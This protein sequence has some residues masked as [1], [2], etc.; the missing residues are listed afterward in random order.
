[1]EGGTSKRFPILITGA[2]WLLLII[3]PFIWGMAPVAFQKL[4]STDDY[5]RMVQVA[6]FMA[7][8]SDSSFHQERLGPAWAPSEMHWT[9]LVDLP[10]A[11]SVSFFQLFMNHEQA[12]YWTATFI[13][14]TLLLVLLLTVRWTAKPL[15][16]QKT[17]LVAIVVTALS[18][19]MLRQF[20]LGGVD[21]HAWQILLV[22][23]GYGC[24]FR[25]IIKPEL[26]KLAVLAGALFAFGLAIGAEILPWVAMAALLQAW[27][28]LFQGERHLRNGLSLG[29]SLCATT[30]LLF[31]VVRFPWE[32]LTHA[33]DTISPAFIFFTASIPLFWLCVALLRGRLPEFKSRLIAASIIGLGVIAALILFI[34]EC[35]RGIYA[36]V[37]PFVKDIWLSHVTEA[38]PWHLYVQ[39]ETAFGFFSLIPLAG[40]LAGCVWACFKDPQKRILWS[41][42]GLVIFCSLCLLMIQVRF[43]DFAGA[44]AII[45]FSWFIVQ[46]A[47]TLKSAYISRLG[48]PGRLARVGMAL[49]FFLLSLVFFLS[50]MDEAVLSR[51]SGQRAS[52]PTCDM[53]DLAEVLNTL[54]PGAIAADIDYGPELLFRTR[55]RVLAA[56]YHRNSAGIKGAFKI[57]SAPSNENARIALDLYEADYALVC[58]EWQNY[59]SNYRTQDR[60]TLY[61]RLLADEDLPDWLK[62][63]ELNDANAFKLFSVF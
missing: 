31:F 42:Y 47:R 54:P 18:W 57:L 38:Q 51:D 28:W 50:R 27:M 8:P 45:P 41:G 34:P 21:H 11:A 33:C 60:K 10:L 39:K 19:P 9:R 4:N 43:G 46:A 24:V 23:G 44:M 40:A 5:L 6:D 16:D 48:H 59:W 22:L 49:C 32:G 17:A 13:P 12:V 56:P 14:A 53:R 20:M 15:T 36:D 7:D 25:T 37:S 1:M 55:H 29:A 30:A 62:R 2:V 58:P 63:H 52:G 26:Q 35:A 61:N 3:A